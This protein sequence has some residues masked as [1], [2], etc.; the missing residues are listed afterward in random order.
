MKNKE[1]YSGIIGGMFFAATYLAGGLPLIPA[2]LVG[3]AAFV[4]GELLM[5]KTIIQ[6]F[7]K[8]DEKNL[9][10]VL[11]DARNK[12]RFRNRFN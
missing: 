6:A 1:I 10:K 4:G 2:I 11:A 3:G 7:D 9:D 12:N 8:V 5:S